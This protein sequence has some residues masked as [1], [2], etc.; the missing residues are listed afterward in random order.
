ML[1]AMIAASRLAE[2]DRE[3]EAFGVQAS[4]LEAL[5]TSLRQRAFS[6]DEVEAFLA[7]APEVAFTERVSSDAIAIDFEEAGPAT[8]QGEGQA[9]LWVGEAGAPEAEAPAMESPV[10]EVADLEALEAAP[11]QEIE[12]DSDVVVPQR[13]YEPVLSVAADDDDADFPFDGTELIQAGARE[14]EL[15]FDGDLSVGSEPIH[16]EMP[17]T[18]TSRP[19]ARP[20]RAPLSQADLDAELAA[21]LSD[22]DD[23][24]ISDISEADRQSLVDVNVELSADVDLSDVLEASSDAVDITEVRDSASTTST[25][26]PL[27]ARTSSIPPDASPGFLGR[28]LHKK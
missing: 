19:Q 20:S 5:L 14:L 4:K 26:P 11:S 6:A 1:Q 22:P 23:T 21:I 28:L 12:L 17:A 7:G 8:D 25:R 9:E 2:V 3:L 16:F 13:T 24:G 15:D 18:G 10:S 27:P